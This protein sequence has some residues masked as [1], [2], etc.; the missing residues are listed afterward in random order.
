MLLTIARLERLY[1]YIN[2][3][4]DL[5]PRPHYKGPGFGGGKGSSL[6]GVLYELWRHNIK[7]IDILIKQC[8]LH[9][10]QHAIYEL[11]VAENRLLKENTDNSVKNLDWKK[12]KSSK[13]YRY[14][15]TC[16]SKKQCAS[17]KK[18][19]MCEV[20]W[21]CGRPGC[22]PTH[23]KYCFGIEW[24]ECED[25]DDANEDD[26]TAV[27][28]ITHLSGS[29]INSREITADTVSLS[30]FDSEIVS[31]EVQDII[32]HLIG[33][34]FDPSVEPTCADFVDW[35]YLDAGDLPT[36]RKMA[37]VE[38]H[39][40]FKK[41]RASALTK[42]HNM[43]DRNAHIYVSR[44]LA[45]AVSLLISCIKTCT[46]CSLISGCLSNGS[47]VRAREHYLCCVC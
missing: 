27:S 11:E 4:I 45:S 47:P 33:I 24:V 34:I 14:C 29:F 40:G 21:I 10:S 8:D 46:H 23:W 5:W 6:L 42:T 9:P 32:E 43:I 18:C 7:A 36:L 20:A 35:R 13:Q 26:S 19:V 38:F 25:V 30:S 41:E 37:L 44:D 12:T 3:T 31:V 2:D 28:S 39:A 1:R 16:N 17:M 22:E 15:V